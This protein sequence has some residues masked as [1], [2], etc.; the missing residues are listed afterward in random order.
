MSVIRN[1]IVTL[2]GPNT[3]HLVHEPGKLFHVFGR[4][5][6][7]ANLPLLV[8]LF[9]QIEH[10][11]TAFEYTLASIKDS[12]DTPIGVDFQ[13]PAIPR[14]FLLATKY[15]ETKSLERLTGCT[16][17]SFWTLVLM[18]MPSVLYGKPNYSKVM[19]ALTPLGVGQV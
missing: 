7:I 11:G 12:R 18:S 1:A 15:L 17:S 14:Q 16:Y 9:C 4:P 3:T 10:D 5:R 2:H 19:E 6:R 13:E 8:V